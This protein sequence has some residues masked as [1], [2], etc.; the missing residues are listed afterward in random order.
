MR[1]I[2]TG[3]I[4]LALNGFMGSTAAQPAYVAGSAGSTQW[5][6]DCGPAGCARDSRAWRL[7]AG[8]R[9][10]GVLALEAFYFDFG[11]ARSS[12]YAVDGAL[13]ASGAGVQSLI[14]WHFG[15]FEFAAKIGL[16]D[17]ANDFR[18]SPTSS[19]ASTRV[20]RKEL[21]AGWMGSYPLSPDVSIRFD[22]DFLTVALD[23]DALFYARG[24]N[25]R[26]TTLGLAYRF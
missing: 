9:F 12:D 2:T 22:I 13:G 20:H 26:S 7:A 23:G 14:G 18:A 16:A 4:A 5:S 1:G 21:V 25:L 6:Y 8:Y 3:L 15:D 10:N 11:R 17:L 19:Y 24:S